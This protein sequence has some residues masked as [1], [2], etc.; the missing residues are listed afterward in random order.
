MSNYAQKKPSYLDDYVNVN[1][2]VTQFY[3]KFPQGRINTH[4]EI[5]E[6]HIVFRAEVFRNADDQQPASTGTAMDKI[7]I[8]QSATEK[9]ET[10]ACGRALAL[11]GFEVKKSLASKE[12]MERYEGR[13]ESRNVATMPA[14][15][16]RVT[17][18]PYSNSANP[19]LATPNQ[20]GAIKTLCLKV[21][22]DS[23]A[24]NFE[25]M[26]SANAS[27]LIKELQEIADQTRG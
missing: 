13:Q 8:N 22:K 18:V 15:T 1:V 7:D 26:T 17:Q 12:E 11:L 3:D 4:Y 6:G 14:R 16:E 27:R 9:T 20:V 5:W 21:K 10:A 24:Y 19:G 25:T 2:R 23:S